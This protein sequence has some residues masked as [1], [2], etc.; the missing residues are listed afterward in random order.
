[1]SIVVTLLHPLNHIQLKIH[2]LVHTLKNMD[3]G[4][5]L[6]NISQIYFLMCKDYLVI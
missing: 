4:A 1:M 2:S 6:E 3:L 5:F